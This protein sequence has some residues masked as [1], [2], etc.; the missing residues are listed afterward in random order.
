MNNKILEQDVTAHLFECE[1]RASFIFVFPKVSDK[2]LTYLHVDTTTMALDPSISFQLATPMQ[3]IFCLKEKNAK[4][5][6]S[7][8]W[9]FSAFCRALTP[10][11]CVLLDVGTR[12]GPKSIYRLWKT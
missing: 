3:V 8:R 6:N 1:S 5:I 9:F 12:P 11:V 10:N 7:H 4:K 2:L